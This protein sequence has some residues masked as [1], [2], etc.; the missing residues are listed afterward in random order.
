MDIDALLISPG[1]Y[2]A[3]PNFPWSILSIGSY[4]S[5]E[6]GY[7]VKILDACKYEKKEFVQNLK[8]NCDKTQLIGVSCMSTNTNFVKEIVDY[9]KDLNRNCKIIIGG[10]H[11]MLQPEQTCLYRNID[12]VAYTEG[13]Y[14]ISSLIEEIKSGRHKYATVPGLY[15]KEDGSIK[16]T[17][18]PELAPFY[19]INYQLLPEDSIKHFPS[20]IQVLSGR[21]CSYKCTFCFNSVC[22]QKWRGRPMSE[23]IVEIENLVSRY[24]PKRIYFRDENFFQ[25]K[26]RIKEFIGLYREKGFTFKWHAAFRASYYGSLYELSF[27]KELESINLEELRI[28]LESGSQRILNYL[29][30]GARVDKVKQMVADLGKLKN[31]RIIYS[32]LIGVPAETYDEYKQTLD[33]AAYVIK[34]DPRARILGPQYFRIYP[35]GELYEEILNKYNF[36]MPK[37]FEG[38]A[39]RYSSEKNRGGFGDEGVIYPWMSRRQA[40]LAQNAYLMVSLYHAL[41]DEKKK[42]RF[43]LL[44]WIL[45]L[46]FILFVQLRMKFRFYD[47]LYEIKFYRSL[48]RLW[49]FFK[50]TKSCK[51]YFKL[52]KKMFSIKIGQSNFLLYLILPQ[53]IKFNLLTE[54]SKLKLD[55]INLRMNKVVYSGKK[56]TEYDRLHFYGYGLFNDYPAKCLIPRLAKIHNFEDTIDLGA[57]SGYFTAE[58]AKYAKR[59]IAVEP[60]SDFRNVIEMRCKNNE[61]SNVSVLCASVF[62]L[63]EYVPE[64]SID[65]LFVIQT[66]H[67]FHNREVVFKILSKVLRRGGRLFVIEPYHNIERI[68]R[69]LKGYLKNYRYKSFYR[70][71]N[72]WMT[73]DFLTRYEFNKYAKSNDF[74][75]IKIRSYRIPLMGILTS[76]IN[77]RF[78]LESYLNRIVLLRNFGK[79]LYFEATKI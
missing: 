8:R 70:D 79:L 72:N 17:V 36:L 56:A 55:E 57:G 16:K 19:D 46:P 28:G 14:A 48:R 67:H 9:I 12:F 6:K 23:V 11:A 50:K 64:Y 78:E 26:E 62:N 66:M 45:I 29:K 63:L 24:N 40:G 21:G 42:K 44:E 74:G 31:T 60:V 2:Y 54:D 41:K 51:N 52:M 18:A 69:M 5:G 53:P 10:P 30:K 3:G 39:H 49:F 75:N 59:V 68:L 38:W 76:G 37:T 61:I 71:E 58:I 13:E 27:L 7:K 1:E 35:G 4:L 73:H 77:R 20:Y 15:Y 43:S 34:K 25:S 47:F 33:L 32:F 65:T 22:G